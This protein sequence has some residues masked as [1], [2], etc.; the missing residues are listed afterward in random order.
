MRT[1]VEM[2]ANQQRAHTR[3]VETTVCARR[4]ATYSSMMPRSLPATRFSVA[5]T[6]IPLETVASRTGGGRTVAASGAD[7]SRKYLR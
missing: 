7:V 3:R 2:G 6:H 4:F 5:K 1:P